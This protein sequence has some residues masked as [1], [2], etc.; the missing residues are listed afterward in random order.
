MF[1][2]G[3]FF[4]IVF[5]GLL[6]DNFVTHFVMDHIEFTVL[7]VLATVG[8][9]VIAIGFIVYSIV[10]ARKLW[11]HRSSDESDPS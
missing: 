10:L 7:G 4:L 3:A 11:F 5:A 9:V 2:S 1:V 8:W 6:Y